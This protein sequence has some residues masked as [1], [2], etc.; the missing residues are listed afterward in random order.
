MVSS[1]GAFDRSSVFKLPTSPARPCSSIIERE[2]TNH[3]LRSGVGCLHQ[4][5]LLNTLSLPLDD[6]YPKPAMCKHLQRPCVWLTANSV[7]HTLPLNLSTTIAIHENDTDH[8]FQQ[9]DKRTTAGHIVVGIR[10]GS[11]GLQSRAQHC[12]CQVCGVVCVRVCSG[13]I[14]CPF[15]AKGKNR[16]NLVGNGC[17]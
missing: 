10:W 6:R 5:G 7:P 12:C 15:V 8:K 14:W 4:R 17:R 9:D 13:L 1:S 3:R 11:Q 2:A 16:L